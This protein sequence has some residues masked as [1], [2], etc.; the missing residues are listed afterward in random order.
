ML[1]LIIELDLHTIIVQ[2]ASYTTN[3][4]WI[5]SFDLLDRLPS[6]RL[7]SPVYPIKIMLQ[8]NCSTHLSWVRFVFTFDYDQEV[9]HSL[10]K[11]LT[12]FI[13]TNHVQNASY[14]TDQIWISEL[15][16][17]RQIAFTTAEEPSL[18]HKNKVRIELYY[19]F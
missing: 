3:Q 6:P 16:S 13:Y 7:R 17:P 8:L 1:Y 9:S 12:H 15:W 2:K 10:Q 11:C 19:T 18:P 4:I 5:Q 14:T